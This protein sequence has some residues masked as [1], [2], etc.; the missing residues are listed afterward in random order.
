[1]GGSGKGHPPILVHVFWLSFQNAFHLIFVIVSVC[2]YYRLFSGFLTNVSQFIFIDFC[3]ISV[4]CCYHCGKK[5][6]ANSIPFFIAM[7]I[8]M[9][10]V[11]GEQSSTSLSFWVCEADCQSLVAMDIVVIVTAIAVVYSSSITIMGG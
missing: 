8:M 7:T 11:D 1:M 5:R 10:I 2:C 3:H 9:V 6:L 4:C